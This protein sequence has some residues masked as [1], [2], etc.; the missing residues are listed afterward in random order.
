MASQPQ[1]GEGESERL[2]IF[3]GLLL[4]LI[5]I[6]IAA[7]DHLF[8]AVLGAI[9]WVHVAPFAELARLWPDVE[10]VPYIGPFLFGDAR[11]AADFLERGG[12]AYMNNNQMMLALT[13]AGRCAWPVYLP[14][15]IWVTLSGS[16][17]RPDLKYRTY[18]SLQQMIET[19]AKNWWAARFMSYT[20]PWDAADISTATIAQERIGAERKA[21]QAEHGFFRATLPPP[22][23][24]GWQRAL[25]PEEWL[26]LHGAC[27]NPEAEARG[28]QSG[29]N[30][31][32]ADLEARDTWEQIDI[33]TLEEL[34]AAQLRMPWSGFGPLKPH[35]KALCAVMALFYAYDVDGGN[36]L[37]GD[38]AAVFDGIRADG[39]QMDAAILR[40]KGMMPRI[41]AILASDAGRNLR[42][43]ADRHA[44][45][46]TAFPAMLT[47]ARKDRG[48]LPSAVFIWLKRVDRGLWYI[49]NSVGSEAIMVEAA[50][51]MAHYRSEVQFEQPILRPATFQAARALLEDYLDVTPERID[52]RHTKAE[53]A[54]SP[55]ER[56]AEARAR[57]AKRRGPDPLAPED[58]KA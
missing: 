41:E 6:G 58:P 26:V 46:E 28:R 37:V 14:V 56:M 2:L 20:N 47:V 44:W 12:F 35:Q 55:A 42:K 29:W 43:V 24:C 15:M 32:L 30:L 5:F 3:V 18:Y 31:V 38:L 27:R 51:A 22:R 9:A 53:R 1:S 17:L 11:N 48:V 4:I 23:I 54:R 36:A 16:T 50:G 40:E 10:T 45:L 34:L 33:D 57:A 13:I 25:R 19:Q 8:K 52:M 21:Q 7:F 49:L 39:S